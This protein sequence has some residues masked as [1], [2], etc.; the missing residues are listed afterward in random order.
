[1][2]GD[3]HTARYADCVFDE[4]HFP[5]LGGDTHPE[6]YQKIVWNATGMQSLD[7]RTSEYELE[8]QRII[9]LQN[10]ANELPDAFTDHKRVTRSYIP[11]V[12]APERV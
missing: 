7:P 6:E 9:H 5:A 8:V 10:L 1:M 12:N 11:T 4:D 2:T 3:L